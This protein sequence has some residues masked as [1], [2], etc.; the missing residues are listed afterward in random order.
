M[1]V[2]GNLNVRTGPGLSYAEI[3]SV[4]YGTTL[5]LVGRNHDGTWVKVRLSNG[6][7]GWVNAAYITTSVPV[8]SL[9]I[10]DGSTGT[11]VRQRPL[12]LPAR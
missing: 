11:A 10:V 3:T 8:T 6:T 5:T 7:E 4:P 12:W 9:P 2:T 1:V